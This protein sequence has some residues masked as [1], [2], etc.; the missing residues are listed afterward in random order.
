MWILGGLRLRRCDSD[1]RPQK[2]ITFPFRELIR[3][4]LFPKT[5]NE[6]P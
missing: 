5:L 1:L 4:I 2:T 6:A 3:I